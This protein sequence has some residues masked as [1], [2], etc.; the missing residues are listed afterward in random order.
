MIRGACDPGGAARPRGRP[1][2][3]TQLAQ[4]VES[5]PPTT[6][7]EALREVLLLTINGIAAGLRNTG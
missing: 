7:A 6:G 2:A 3:A 5:L 1:A 4:D